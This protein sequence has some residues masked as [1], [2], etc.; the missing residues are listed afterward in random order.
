MVPDFTV[1]NFEGESFTL[2]DA[3]Q[4]EKPVVLVSGSISCNRF[5]FTFED[6]QTG[7]YSAAREF[8]LTHQDD[9]NW[10]FIYGIEAHPGGGECPSNCPPTITTDTLV[11]QHPDY[12]YRRWALKTWNDA[13]GDGFPFPMY[14]DNPDNAIYN[15]FFERAFGLV[16]LRC[17]GTV[18]LRADWAHDFLAGDT[19]ALLELLTDETDCTTPW[20]GD[21]NNT[22]SEVSLGLSEVT[23]SNP[24]FPNPANEMIK[25]LAT[26]GSTVEIIEISGQVAKTIHVDTPVTTI[27][28]GDLESGMYFVKTQGDLHRLVIQH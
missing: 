23:A 28:L 11:I 24:F 6:Q 26:A 12:H 21:A 3:L 10:V 25:L 7:A 5:R 27:P 19:S 13:M 1:Y 14:V 20:D 8:L 17:D 9:F 2:S 15:H 4:D 18:A 22:A 16:A